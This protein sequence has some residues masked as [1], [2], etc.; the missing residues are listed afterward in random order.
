[1]CVRQCAAS[2]PVDGEVLVAPLGGRHGD[3][4][5]SF[6]VSGLEVV[7]AFFAL[8]PIACWPA[9]HG[10]LLH[11]F[12]FWVLDRL[13]LTVFLLSLPA[14]RGGFVPVAL[15]GLGSLASPLH[16]PGHPV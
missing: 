5:A 10:V 3:R 15:L 2:F 12:A 9:R 11:A 1:M 4:G 7:G 14:A 16:D 13:S 8:S 6:L